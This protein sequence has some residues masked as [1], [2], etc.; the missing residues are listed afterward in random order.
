MKDAEEHKRRG[1]AKMH[2]ERDGSGEI[3]ASIGPW[4]GLLIVSFVLSVHLS[5]L[6]LSPYLRAD[7][8]SMIVDPA[9]RFNSTRT[10]QY[11]H[12]K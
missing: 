6:C 8:F 4:R 7:T 11:I 10:K 1:V 9:E 3:T 2:K 5:S 12:H